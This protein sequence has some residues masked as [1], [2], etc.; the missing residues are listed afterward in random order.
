MIDPFV[1]YHQV[2]DAVKQSNIASRLDRK[3]KITGPTDWRNSGIDDDHFGAPLAC[4]PDVICRNRSTFGDIRS[5]NP[6]HLRL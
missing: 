3:E 6:Y 1:F 4:L 5:A 2:E